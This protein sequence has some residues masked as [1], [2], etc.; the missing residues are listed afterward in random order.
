MEK[1]QLFF[2]KRQISQKSNKCRKTKH[3]KIFGDLY[4][5]QLYL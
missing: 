5:R 3:K 4:L 2:K 1:E